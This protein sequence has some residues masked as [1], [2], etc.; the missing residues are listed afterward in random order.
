MSACYKHTK[1]HKS[2]SLGK[3]S[4]PPPLSTPT[5]LVRPTEEVL[6]VVHPTVEDP[7]E[8]REVFVRT[9]PAVVLREEMGLGTGGR[10]HTRQDSSEYRIDTFQITTCWW[11][12]ARQPSPRPCWR[13]QLI[14]ASSSNSLITPKNEEET[15][16]FRCEAP[17]SSIVLHTHQN[18][19]CTRANAQFS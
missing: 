14:S 13:S 7:E 16:G 9:E 10:W 18:V 6:D 8:E 4:D 1:T 15:N 2:S 11:S 3:S 19:I 5:V 17:A 12:L